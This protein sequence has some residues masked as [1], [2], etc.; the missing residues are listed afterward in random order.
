NYL[1]TPEAMYSEEGES[2]WSC[3][4]SSYGRVR[5]FQGDW[6]G[7][8]PFRYQGQYEDSETG[9]YYNRFRYYSPEEGMY[10]SQDP[11]GLAGGDELYAYVHDPNTWI[12]EFGL[13]KNSN[14]TVGDWV[15]YDVIDPET[16]IAKVGIGKAEDVMPTKNNANRRAEASARKVRKD[17]KFKNAQAV[18][19]R[20][21]KGIT[22]GEMKEIEARRVRLLRTWG[23]N[24]PHNKERD[25]RY[26]PNKCSS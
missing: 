15:L 23:L 9:L 24:L 10:I 21:Y 26:K 6:K 12:D 1:G 3:E 5:N 17:S 16:G 25:K 18:V 8:C 19:R 2:V 4:L 22:K 20:T 7:D 11:I 14:D 13:N